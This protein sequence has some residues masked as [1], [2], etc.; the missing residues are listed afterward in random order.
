VTFSHLEIT[1]NTTVIIANTIVNAKERIRTVFVV[2]LSVPNT[3]GIGPMIM[4]PPAFVSPS[5]AF[6]ATLKKSKK[7]GDGNH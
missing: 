6:L 2:S 3:T 7:D 1:Y 4:T 5:S